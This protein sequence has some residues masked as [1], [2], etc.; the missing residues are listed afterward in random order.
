MQLSGLCGIGM[1][2]LR[3]FDLLNFVLRR[4][5]ATECLFFFEFFLIFFLTSKK[6]NLLKK[7]LVSKS[8]FTTQASH[9]GWLENVFQMIER[10]F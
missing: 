4:I 8:Y 3:L 10:H 6:S 2:N 1:K 5:Q 9:G 7:K